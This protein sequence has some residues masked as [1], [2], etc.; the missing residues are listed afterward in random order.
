MSINVCNIFR[1]FTHVVLDRVKVAA[2][3]IGSTLITVLYLATLEGVIHKLAVLPTGIIAD[4]DNDDME[5]TSVCLV[6]VIYL[7]E[8]P[9]PGFVRSLQLHAAKV[10][11]I[12]LYGIVI[13]R[14]SLGGFMRL[15]R[16][17]VCPV[18]PPNSNTKEVEKSKLAQTCPR[19]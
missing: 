6:E 3:S 9:R 8:R 1:R 7:S 10:R 15:V 4:D 11:F 2:G 17:S 18:L 14:P 13:R 12:Q 5:K 19:A 16:P